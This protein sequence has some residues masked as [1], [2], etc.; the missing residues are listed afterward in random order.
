[1]SRFHA[2]PTTPEALAA[3]IAEAFAHMALDP[4]PATIELTADVMAAPAPEGS[5]PV[6]RVALPGPEPSPAG[7]VRAFL[8]KAEAPILAGG[9]ARHAADP[10]ARS[11]RRSTPR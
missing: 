3:A 11:P 7:R 4:A 9:G 8:E 1:M 2:R 10:S 5:L 6:A